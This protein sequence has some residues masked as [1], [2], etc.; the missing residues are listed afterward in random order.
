VQHLERVEDLLRMKESLLV[1]AVGDK[2]GSISVYHPVGDQTWFYKI[3]GPS[4]V[5]AAEK[6]AFMEFLQSIRFPKP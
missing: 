6:G 3:A 4:A 1:E 2:N 5:V